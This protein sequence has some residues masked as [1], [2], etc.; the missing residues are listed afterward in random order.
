MREGGQGGDAPGK[1]PHQDE[2]IG[3]GQARVERRNSPFLK[4]TDEDD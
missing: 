3:D 1:H 4:D 2:D